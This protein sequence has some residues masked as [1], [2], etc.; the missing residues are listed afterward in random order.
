[1][2]RVM[3]TDSQLS[4]LERLEGAVQTLLARLGDGLDVSHRRSPTPAPPTAPPE[5]QQRSRGVSLDED[6]V[7]PVFVLRDLAAESGTAQVNVSNGHQISYGNEDV[8]QAGIL[9]LS[10]ATLLVR[11]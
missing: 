10:D 2:P 4:R 8:I 3:Y 7:A 6:A 11:M 1:M 5:P 9:S